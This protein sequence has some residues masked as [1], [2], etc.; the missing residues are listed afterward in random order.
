VTDTGLEELSVAECWDRLEVARIGRV[1]FLADDFPIVFPV[2]F[3]VVRSA[4]RPHWRAIRTRPG[5]LLDQAKL[6]VALQIDEFDSAVRGGWSVLVRGTLHHVDPDAADFRDRF[7]PDPWLTDD[8]DSW[9]VIEPFAISGR[10]LAGTP[11]EWAF[12]RDAYL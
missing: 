2:N 1:A 12:R 4:G 3:R 8:R 7:D 5:A 6:P 10:S 11:A 9:I